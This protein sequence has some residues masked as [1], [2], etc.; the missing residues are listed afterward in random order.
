MSQKV[1]L[2]EQYFELHL[3]TDKTVL[4]E[5]NTLRGKIGPGSCELDSSVGKNTF[6]SLPY[7]C[8]ILELLGNILLYDTGGF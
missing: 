5:P 4:P 1:S 2:G 7:Q 3:A 6:Y 8:I